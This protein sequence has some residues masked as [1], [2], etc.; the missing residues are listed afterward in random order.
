[1]KIKQ[2]DRQASD[3]PFQLAQPARR[4][5]AGAGVQRL[6]QLTKLSE[7]EVKQLHG[8]GPNALEQLRRALRVKGL[9]FANEER[10]KVVAPMKKTDSREG[11]TPSQLITKQI[12]GL[13]DWRGKLLARLRELIREAAPDMTEE[14][15]WDTAVWS[16]KGLVCSAGPFKDHVKLNF[17]KGACLKDPKG[18]FNAGLDAKA[19]RAIDFTEGDAVDASALKGLIRAAVAYNASGG[20]K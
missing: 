13:A 3:L 14:W 8:I 20:K 7:T 12:A 11:M 4:A 17:F 19:T 2:I 16:Q 18:L 6:E 10:I 5:L 9:S 15:K 1:M